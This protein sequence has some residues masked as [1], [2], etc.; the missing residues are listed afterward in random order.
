MFFVHLLK[1]LDISF[2]VKIDR[3]I[4][5]RVLILEVKVYIFLDIKI[6]KIPNLKINQKIR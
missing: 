6:K 1:G 5:L 2:F 3:N 4:K